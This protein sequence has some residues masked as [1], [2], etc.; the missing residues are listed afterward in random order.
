MKNFILALCLSLTAGT[1]AFGQT[2]TGDDY[3]KGEGYVGYS[4]GQVDTG[5]D[6]GSTVN[7]F[8]RDRRNFHGVNVSGVYNF[9]R[10]LGVKGDVSATFNNERF[11]SSTAAGGT[12][13]N[14]S[15]KTNNQLWNFVGGVQLKDNE[16]SGVF[17]PFAHAMVGGAHIRSRIS[18]LTCSPT[19]NCP[20]VIPEDSETAS[21]TGFAG[22]FGGGIDFRVGDR[23]QIRAIQVDYN[24]IRAFGGTDHNLRLGAGIVF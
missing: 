6:S 19:L 1:F 3:K 4:N 10:Y 23:F 21:T 16:R 14:F 24:P 2:T 13:Y 9:N 15:A 11:T 18:D 22:V 5:A 8:F 17:K 7:D 12:T 20:V